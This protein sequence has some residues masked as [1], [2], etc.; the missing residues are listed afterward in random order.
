MSEAIRPAAAPGSGD[1]IYT[2]KAT[3]DGKP[4][5]VISDDQP[6]ARE[7]QAGRLGWREVRIPRKPGNRWREGAAVQDER[8]R[9]EGPEDRATDQLRRVS[10]SCRW[11]CTRKRS[12]SG[13]SFYACTTRS[14]VR[15]SWRMPMPE[16]L[17]EGRPGCGRSGSADIEAYGVQRW[18]GELA[19]ALRQQTYRPDPI[20]RV[21]IAKANGKL[22]L[23]HL[24]LRDRDCMQQRCWCWKRSLE[25]MFHQSSTPTVR[26]RRPT[27]SG[28][29]GSADIRGHPE[30]VD[31]DLAN[32]SGSIPMPSY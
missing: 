18:L 6:D 1:S 12:R 14:A 15:T 9:S 24:D 32:Y 5:G 8:K 25:P 13:L 2:R 20:R 3:Q 28:R 23:G 16:P 26:A 10:R 4:L 30:V 27:G 19:L 21:S 29:G 7:G 11:R 17:Q 31:A 22:G